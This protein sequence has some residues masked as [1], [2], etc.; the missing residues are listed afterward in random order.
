M[1]ATNVTPGNLASS[2]PDL[3]DA[4]SLHGRR[5]R[6]GISK[7]RAKGS[8]PRTAKPSAHA[9]TRDSA[10]RGPGVADPGRDVALTVECVVSGGNRPR[11]CQV[12]SLGTQE[13]EAARRPLPAF[14]ASGH[15][16]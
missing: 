13:R 4:L 10:T 5:Q 15:R 14:K 16:V 2:G 6:M 1:D 3:G 11:R 12:T 7:N 9:R 8:K